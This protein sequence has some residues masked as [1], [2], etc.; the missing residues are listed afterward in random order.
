MT[1]GKSTFY[2]VLGWDESS[3]D[4]GIGVPET[5]EMYWYELNPIQQAAAHKV[6]FFENSWDWVSLAEW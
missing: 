4:D 1:A 2:E 3:W 6:C 5:D